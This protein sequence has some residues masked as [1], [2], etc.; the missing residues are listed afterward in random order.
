[1]F[2]YK[3][4]RAH[5]FSSYHSSNTVYD[6]SEGQTPQFKLTIYRQQRQLT[7]MEICAAPHHMKTHL[8]VATGNKNRLTDK[9]HDRITQLTVAIGLM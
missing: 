9:R 3:T 8:N 5:V 2:L 1:M 4:C 6:T 7:Q